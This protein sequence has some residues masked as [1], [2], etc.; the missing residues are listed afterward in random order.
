MPSIF[1]LLFSRIALARLLSLKVVLPVSITMITPSAIEDNKVVSGPDNNGGVSIKTKSKFFFSMLI[2]C[3]ILGDPNITEGSLIKEPLVKTHKPE[4]S[5]RST[6]D[7]FSDRIFQSPGLIDNPNI[8][9]RL[10]LRK[11]ASTIATDFFV[12]TKAIPRLAVIVLFPSWA[13]LLVIK[14]DDIAALLKN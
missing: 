13:T 14:K 6:N 1:A 2:S 12:V 9:C 11:F 4:G 7:L 3:S 10:G 8:W 5:L